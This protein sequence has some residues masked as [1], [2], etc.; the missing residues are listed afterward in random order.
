[1]PKEKIKKGKMAKRKIIL[2]RAFAILM[3]L[4]MAYAA[5][6]LDFNA[7]SAALNQSR[8]YI[9]EMNE[10]GLSIERVNDTLIQAEQ[11]FNAQYALM[12]T[13]G[14]ADFSLILE[15]TNE[16]A[17]LKQKAES[18][19]DEIK[20]LEARLKNVRKQSEAYAILEKAKKEFADERYDKVSALV[21]DAYSKVS[22]EQA[23]QT[24]FLAIY[25]AGT[26]TLMD[27][28][29][30]RWREIASLAAGMILVYFIAKKR[31]KIMLIKRNISGLEFEK[32]IIKKLVKKT[33]YEYFHLFKI[34]EELYHIRI[35]K[36][37]ELVRDIDRKIPLLTE[38]IEKVKA[39]VQKEQEGMPK[40]LKIRV[41]LSSII[42]ILILA[43]LAFVLAELRIVSYANMLNLAN[44]TAFSALEKISQITGALGIFTLAISGLLIIA[45]ALLIAYRLKKKKQAQMPQPEEKPNAP[46]QPWHKTLRLFIA[47][48]AVL[49]ISYFK[50]LPKSMQ[51][52]KQYKKLLREKRE[53]EKLKIRYIRKQRLVLFRIKLQEKI[54]YLL[55]LRMAKTGYATKYE[56][57]AQGKEALKKWKVLGF[58]KDAAERF[59]GFLHKLVSHKPSVERKG[60]DAIKKD[61][62]FKLLLEGI[63]KKL[64]ELCGKIK[65]IRIN[66]GNKQKISE[67]A[68]IKKI[69]GI[70][71]IKIHLKK[72]RESLM[73]SDLKAAKNEYLEIMKLY[74]GL[75]P[76]EKTRVYNEIK[77]LYYERKIAEV[78]KR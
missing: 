75:A 6:A 7:T 46:S 45:A 32:K 77:S 3:L 42:M 52:S 18:M 28:L 27:F 69:D 1:M 43:A 9:Q 57:A 78:V 29:K 15:R 2:I 51:E 10:A 40:K 13:G 48:R 16:I 49:A 38:E 70:S 62:K 30:K 68:Q 74:D 73:K 72:A 67:A 8:I 23:F 60:R 11:L 12:K 26:K 55:H 53:E 33:Q 54:Y 71:I 5:G 14:I 17:S 37:A 21:D 31:I 4:P 76:L 41:V 20:T 35:E 63:N 61:N 65:Q 50:S 39:I 34:P 56:A 58:A 19:S 25:E 59:R 66:L 24:R 36:Y 44:Y 64:K 47:N 22:E